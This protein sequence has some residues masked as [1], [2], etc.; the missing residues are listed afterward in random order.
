LFASS[1]KTGPD[2]IEHAL[3]GRPSQ[4]PL[5]GCTMANDLK[6]WYEAIGKKVKTWGDSLA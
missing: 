3:P 6:G 4:S 2:L 5:R 1:E